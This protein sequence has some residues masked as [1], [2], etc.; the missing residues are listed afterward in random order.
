MKVS[1]IISFRASDGDRKSNLRGVLNYLSPFIERGIGVIVVEQDEQSKI[2]WPIDGTKHL[3]IKNG[4]VFNKGL[5]YNV[6]AKFSSGDALIF[7]DADLYIRRESYMGGLAWLDRYDVVDPYTIIFYIPKANSERFAR[8]LDMAAVFD[9]G[10]A[11]NR[12]KAIVTS[13]GIFSIR[14][15]VFFS[16]KGFDET[17]TGFGY[18]DNI[19]DEKMRKMGVKIKTI[20]DWCVHVYHRSV[21]EG[22]DK[23]NPYFDNFAR[24]KQLFESYTKMTTEQVLQRIQSVNTWGEAE[25]E[26]IAH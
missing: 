19:F 2:D 1:I 22:F 12:V 3:L 24:N 8:D 20:D 23:K 15:D 10:Y 6:G 16:L 4:G 25:Y 9:P 14:R 7:H 17:C 21:R 26:V 13:G 11:D 5:G 18:E